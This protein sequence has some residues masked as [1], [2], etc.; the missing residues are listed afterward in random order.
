M[1]EHSQFIISYCKK[2]KTGVDGNSESADNGKNN[3]ERKG[4]SIRNCSEGNELIWKYTGIW[5]RADEITND[6]FLEFRQK[7][8]RMKK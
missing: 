5:D 8:E 4:V 3:L 2:Q 7:T 6:E 1:P